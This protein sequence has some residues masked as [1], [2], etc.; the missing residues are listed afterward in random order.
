MALVPVVS[1]AGGAAVLSVDVVD[2]Q[3]VGLHATNNLTT[4]VSVAVFRSGASVWSVSV[5]VGGASMALNKPRQFTWSTADDYRV[6][7]TVACPV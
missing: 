3:A 5:P 2:D 7:V 4:P 1:V 6:E